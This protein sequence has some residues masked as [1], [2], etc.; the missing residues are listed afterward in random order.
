MF[1]I[2]DSQIVSD[3]DENESDGDI[4]EVDN[5]ELMLH[6]G[7]S[8]DAMSNNNDSDS[9]PSASRLSGEGE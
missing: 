8:R 4:K 9:R 2:S 7:A 1:E 5:D 3:D 6:D